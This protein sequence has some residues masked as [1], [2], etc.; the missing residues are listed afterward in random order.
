L[1]QDT[2]PTSEVDLLMPVDLSS[3]PAWAVVL[4]LVLV[5]ATGVSRPRMV[6]AI[7][8]LW[9]WGMTVKIV[10]EQRRMA[11]LVLKSGAE[12]QHSVVD[13]PELSIH[14][15][16]PDGNGKDARRGRQR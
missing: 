13:G 2:Q 8:H 12:L 16:R 6:G 3:L 15:A 14:T 9:K 7:E 1:Q 11:T 4:M 5:A 10:R